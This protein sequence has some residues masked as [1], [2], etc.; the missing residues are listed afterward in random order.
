M[1]KTSR[2]LSA[3]LESERP[4]RYIGD[5]YGV[6]NQAEQGGLRVAWGF[7]DVYE[8]GMSHL[9][10]RLLHAAL[11]SRDDL[12]V[13]RFFLPWP[14][15]QLK[16]AERE[17]AL[18]SLESQTPLARFDLLGLSVQFEL[19]FPAVL[20]LLDLAQIPRRASQRHDGAWP[21]VLVGGVGALNPE[22]LAPFVDAFFLGEADAAIHE[23]VDTLAGASS[24]AD[25]IE[26]LAAVEGIYLPELTEVDYPQGPLGVAAR[27]RAVPPQRLP[28][29]RRYVA[30]LDTLEQPAVSLVPYCALI[31]D[32]VTVEIQRGCV[33]GCRFC[34][35]GFTTRPTRQ[36]SADVVLEQARTQLRKTGYQRLSLLSLS[37]GD[38]PRLQEI[39]AALIEEHGDDRV[40]IS[41]PSLR[42][43]SL[44]PVVARQIGAAGQSTF[45]LAPEAGTD[46]L[47]RVI[48]KRNSDEDLLASVR[49]VV[50]AGYS[51]L[52]LYFMVGLPTE[53][54]EDVR[55]ISELARRVDREA[56]G[57][58]RRVRITVAISTF[59]PKP[60]TPFQ[61]EAVAPREEVERKQQL[62]L[63]GL[64]RSIQVKWHDAGQSEVEAI[65]ARADRRI[66]GVIERVVSPQSDGMDAWSDHF[67]L[68]RWERALT[69]ASAAGELPPPE[70]QLAARA[71]E[72]PLPWDH[73]DVG[74]ERAYFERERIAALEASWREECSEGPC[75]ACG[76][77]PEDPLHRLA[78]ALPTRT[79]A[80]AGVTV[81]A[82]RPP[83]PPPGVRIWFHKVG[84]AALISHLEMVGAFERA[85]RRAKIPFAFSAGYRPKPRLRFS[86]ALPLGASSRCEFVEIGL[87]EELTPEE[88]TQRLGAQLPPGLEL[89]RA[90][91]AQGRSL[92][93]AV[94][95]VRWRFEPRS[96]AAA[97]L[98][99]ESVQARLRGDEPLLVTRSGGKEVDL[100]KRVLG[101]EGATGGAVLV[102]C[103]FDQQGSARPAELLRG[104]LGLDDEQARGVAVTREAWIT[105]PAEGGQSGGESGVDSGPASE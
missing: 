22:P 29:Q 8:V 95:A 45:T 39:L 44:H 76:V 13:E 2:Y 86:P 51:Q 40:A 85:A 30:N 61:W 47:R 97:R 15:L 88:L 34:Q 1:P 84:R 98:D 105:T 96:G 74:V 83:G 60:H 25:S 14:D 81:A 90:E 75:D 42:T 59:V 12:Q 103:S 66:A 5:E 17:L 80:P 48:N 91:P 43:E 99:L 72:L 67:R 41:L 77:C 49:A 79:T 38:H 64:P 33:Q 87:R 68:D 52:K 57:I 100:R 20:K 19:A 16:L 56:R 27:V 32:R 94:Q 7:P 6:V 24:R 50:G 53:R 21:L 92:T 73:L 82:E 10:Y 37:A 70:A 3:L 69:E 63:D 23:I 9:G 93:G 102:T 18:A 36:R 26:R 4:S 31:H 55:A 35:A 71:P 54:D 11:A 78:T 62:V 58:R 104:L 101:V 46:R 28:V 65:L 89:Q